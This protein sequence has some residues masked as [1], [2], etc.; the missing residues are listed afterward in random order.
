MRTI[1]F[2][3]STTRPWD[4]IAWSPEKGC[5]NIAFAAVADTNPGAYVSE[6]KEQSPG[7]LA[8]S[9]ETPELQNRIWNELALIWI[10][11]EPN[12]ETIRK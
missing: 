5:R 11:F 3:Y 2:V 1:E 9:M 12:I 10:K 4:K 7:G 8:E 6:R